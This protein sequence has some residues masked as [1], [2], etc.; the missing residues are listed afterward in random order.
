M[1]FRFFPDRIEALCSDPG[2]RYATWVWVPGG[3]IVRSAEEKYDVALDLFRHPWDGYQ[4]NPRWLSDSGQVVYMPTLILQ[5]KKE[6]VSGRNIAVLERK[7]ADKPY[8]FRPIPNPRLED[9]LVFDIKCDDP[10]FMLP[11]GKPIE[12][13]SRVQNFSRASLA[14]V[15]RFRVLT[16]LDRKQVETS[17]Y[18]IKLDVMQNQPLLLS[19]TLKEP[20]VYRA[21]LTLLEQD[22][23]LRKIEWVFVYDWDNWKPGLTRPPDFAE[24][25]QKTLQELRSQALDSVLT[26]HPDQWGGWKVYKVN[27]SSLGKRRCYG[28]YCVP[29][30]K[31]PFPASVVFPGNGVYKLPST[32]KG[33]VDNYVFLVIQVH[34][35]DVDLSNLPSPWPW[36]LGNYWS[37]WP[38]REDAFARVIYTNAV[39]AVDFLM[40]RPEVNKEAIF[41]DGMSQGGGLS[42]ITAGLDPRV[43]GVVARFPA[44]CR[45]D[46]TYRWFL[47][48][49]FPWNGVDFKPAGMTEE[50]FLKILSYYDPANFIPDISCPVMA[51]VGL[52]D[53]VTIGGNA[54]A[55]LRQVKTP[56]TLVNGVWM[57][58]RS[59]E[60]TSK[61]YIDWVRRL[62]AEFRQVTP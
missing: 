4:K 18:K 41:V 35:Y 45:L 19:G 22:N 60:R 54:L 34:G 29:P 13:P 9:A 26:P 58:H 17:D 52:Q 27:F 7:A 53:T 6:V 48:A 49:P 43:K 16:F 25:W 50:A 24:F 42:L 33:P 62:M 46:W 32:Y 38:S 11:R 3:H 55:A 15:V 23:M 10:N 37:E 1:S 5:K 30:G 2:G 12:F 56:L 28:W 21:E 36:K 40:S 51:V 57:D 59:S 14:A 44:L 31:G 20:G 61:A 39:R 47:K 8:V